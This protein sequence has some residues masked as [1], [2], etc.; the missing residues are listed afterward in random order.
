MFIKKLAMGIVGSTLLSAAFVPAA[1][2]ETY[3]TEQVVQ[4]QTGVW[5]RDANTAKMMGNSL[6]LG[7]HKRLNGNLYSGRNTNIG[8][9]ADTR[10]NTG[11]TLKDMEAKNTFDG[12]MTV[13]APGIARGSNADT[14]YEDGRGHEFGLNLDAGIRR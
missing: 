9:N 10:R 14:A 1:M 7:N 8:I 6:T 11:S 5:T 13:Y 3:S 12:E 2:A 4:P